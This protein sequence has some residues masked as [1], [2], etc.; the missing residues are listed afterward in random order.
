VTY[1]EQQIADLADAMWQL[2]DDM[3]KDG[4]SVC[5][6]AKAQ[7][8]V[9]YEPFITDIEREAYAGLMPLAEALEIEYRS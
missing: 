9:A 2:L 5:L 7:A 1:T 4:L 6:A 3:G 8:R